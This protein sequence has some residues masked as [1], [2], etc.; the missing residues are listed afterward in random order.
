MNDKNAIAIIISGKKQ[1]IISQ[2]LKEKRL[3]A[4][5]LTL[6]QCNAQTSVIEKRQEGEIKGI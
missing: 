3:H 5:S 1:S 6:N 4:H 2:I